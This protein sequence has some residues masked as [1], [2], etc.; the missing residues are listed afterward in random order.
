[1]TG[2]SLQTAGYNGFA[3]SVSSM[4]NTGPT[5][6]VLTPEVSADGSQ[7][8]YNVPVISYSTNNSTSTITLYTPDSYYLSLPGG[9]TNVRVR[10]S[11][12]MGGTITGTISGTSAVP[13]FTNVRSYINVLSALNSIGVTGSSSVTAI[14]PGATFTG[15]WEQDLLWQGASMTIFATQNLTISFQQSADAINVTS[16]DIYTYTANSTGPDSSKLFN[17]VSNYHRVTVTNNGSTAVYPIIQTYTTPNWAPIPAR[18]LL[19]LDQPI[20][21]NYDSSIT[22][23]IINGQ[24]DSGNYIPVPVAPQGY[25]E[26]AVRAPIGP[27]GSMHV[28]NFIPVIQ[29]DA[30]YGL[31]TNNIAVNYAG[32]G[33]SGYV[34]NSAF[35]VSAPNTFGAYATLQTAQRITYRSGQ[36]IIA[37]FSGLFPNGGLPGSPGYTGSYQLIGIGHAED[38]V[39]FGYRGATFGILYT[40]RG[41]RQIVSLGISSAAIFPTVPV[42]LAGSTF[43]VPITTTT[44]SAAAYQVATYGGYTGWDAQAIGN[45]VTFVSGSAANYGAIA[46]F[47]YGVGGNGGSFSLG[48]TGGAATETFYPQSQWNGDVLNGSGSTA[49]PSGVLANWATGNVF[50][51]GIQYLGFGAITFEVECSSVGN[52]A[53]FNIV[54][55]MKLPNSLSATSFR[56]PSFPLS[57]IAYGVT[58]GTSTVQVQ[59]GSLAAFNEGIVKYTANKFSYTY[60]N[61]AAISATTIP[62]FTIQNGLVYGGIPNQSIITLVSLGGSMRET[63][64]TGAGYLTATVFLL[65]NAT[66]S[67][68]TNF[69]SFSSKSMSYVDTGSTGVTYADN[70]Q[71]LFSMQLA[72]NNSYNFTLPDEISF[73]QEII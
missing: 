13:N 34:D 65:K 26:C 55:T 9:S 24:T 54:H 28:E 62:I 19:P 1:M 63:T 21:V 30:I 18:G 16:S 49:N 53:A 38:G 46:N 59:S 36:G 27:F 71:Q 6:N 2:S 32:S 56:N 20:K 44:T 50:K 35:I 5:G 52:D 47:T 15:L 29:Q 14:A 39:Y 51:I 66:L 70:S 69:S 7:T 48:T 67:G 45:T 17:L 40:N 33:A 60:S 58:G 31:N 73:S 72:S 4:G 43:T 68:P 12:Y 41:K 37:A 22:R 23:A 8:W 61:P 25:L 42:T 3:I 57:L 10:C 64:V 11:G